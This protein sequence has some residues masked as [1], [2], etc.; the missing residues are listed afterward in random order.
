MSDKNPPAKRIRLG[1]VTAS[2]WK[3]EGTDRPFYTVTLQ[4]AYKDANGT[5]QNGDNF[6]ADQL[7]N[8]A[9]C[10]QKANDFIASQ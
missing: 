1:L 5:W 10:L 2:V 7:L 4:V 3:N 6:N 9:W 8:A